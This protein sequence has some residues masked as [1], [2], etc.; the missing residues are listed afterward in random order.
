VVAKLRDVPRGEAAGGGGLC[1]FIL[2]V[3]NEIY[4]LHAFE[5]I[6][7]GRWGGVAER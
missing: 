2:M 3:R 6:K 5:I 7:Y 1:E 4:R